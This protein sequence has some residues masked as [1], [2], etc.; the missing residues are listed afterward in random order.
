M[1]HA[2]WCPVYKATGPC[3]CHLRASAASGSWSAA[4]GT[5]ANEADE[6]RLDKELQL[7]LKLTKIRD[8]AA[9]QLYR[10]ST[11]LAGS[12]EEFRKLWDHFFVGEAKLE[13][14]KQA[15]IVLDLIRESGEF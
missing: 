2:T 4:Y 7:N 10:N 13:F 3:R 8:E 6:A 9:F 11:E 15:D 14:F 12:E 1:S 5:L